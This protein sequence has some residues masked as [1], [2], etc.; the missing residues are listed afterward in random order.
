MYIKSPKT[1][2]IRKLTRKKNSNHKSTY[3]PRRAWREDRTR[4]EEENLQS[5]KATSPCINKQ[6]TNLPQFNEANYYERIFLYYNK[7]KV[8]ERIF[9]TKSILCV[10]VC[11]CTC[12][13][14]RYIM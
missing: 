6:T 9:G 4:M 12:V 13:R 2:E 8:R 3:L 5:Y 11:V 7:C 1:E 14:A 10:R